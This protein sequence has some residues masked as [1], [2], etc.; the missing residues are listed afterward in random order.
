M[1]VDQITQT[2]GGRDAI[3]AWLGI[4]PDAVKRWR[5]NGVPPKHWSK[6]VKKAKG[7]I[8]YDQLSVANAKLPDV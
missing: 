1:N 7:G 8:S 3:A 2:L 6:I 4:T 5:Y